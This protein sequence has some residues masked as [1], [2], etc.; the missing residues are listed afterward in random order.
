MSKQRLPQEAQYDSQ[1]LHYALKYMPKMGRYISENCPSKDTGHFTVPE[2][3]AQ[4]LGSH[5]VM[6]QLEA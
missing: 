6:S 2:T 3:T 4:D 5:F 1:H